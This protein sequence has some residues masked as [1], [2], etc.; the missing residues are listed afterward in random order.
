MSATQSLFKKNAKSFSF[1]AL[2]LDKSTVQKITV[3]YEFCRV[4]DDIADESADPI[5]AKNMLNNIKIDIEQK[6]SDQKMIYEFIKFL[7]VETIETNYVLDLLTGVISDCNDNVKIE[8][9]TE[10]LNYS[11]RVA[12]TVGAMMCSVLGVQERN[13]KAAIIPATHLGIAMQLTNIARDIK[14]D[15]QN[16]R[17]YIPQSWQTLTSLML[18]DKPLSL[19]SDASMACKKLLDIADLYYDSSKTGYAYLPLRSRVCILIAST[20]YRAIG[21]KIRR[22]HYKYWEGR[23]YLNTFEKIFQLMIALPNILLPN[24]WSTQKY[25]DTNLYIG[26]PNA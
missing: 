8:N 5:T 21:Q 23:V 2:I 22:N 16:K 10:L 1:A 20:I 6:F 26:N 9:E 19:E 25:C 7:A 15:A 4:V 3:L 13:M 17:I 11:Y 24:F 18:V 14:E 12:G